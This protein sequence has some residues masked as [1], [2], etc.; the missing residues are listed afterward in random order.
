MSDTSKRKNLKLGGVEFKFAE[1]QPELPGNL[2]L[3]PHQKEFF[4]SLNR[5]L[6]QGNSR[7]FFLKSMT[8]SGKTIANIMPAINN[9]QNILITYPTNQLIRDQ[10]RSIEKDAD[11]FNFQED[12]E[13]KYLN[14]RELQREK[15]REGKNISNLIEEKLNNANQDDSKA[16]IFLTSPD[17]LYNILSAKYWRAGDFSNP[18]D[19]AHEAVVGSLDYFVFDEFHMYDISGETSILNMCLLLH[20]NKALSKPIVFSSATSD[21]DF[22]DNLAKVSKNDIKEIDDNQ[23]RAEDGDIQI[24][25]KVDL[26][27][28]LG[29]KWKGPQK[30]IEEREKKI[31]EL[32]KEETEMTA[33]FESVKNTT[34]VIDELEEEFELSEKNDEISYKTGFDSSN[35]DISDGR[36]KLGTQTISVGIDFSTSDLFFESYRARDFLQ[37]LGRVGREGNQ[38]KAVCYTSEY[39]IPGLDK[40]KEEYSDRYRFQN[41][42]IGSEEEEGA[43]ESRNK[44]WRYP[45]KY[46]YIELGNFKEEFA[47]NLETDVWELSNK[48][49]RRSPKS[50]DRYREFI[51]NFRDPGTPQIAVATQDDIKFRDLVRFFEKRSFDREQHVRTL[52]ADEKDFLEK[53][54]D[55]NPVN[56]YYMERGTIKPVL[57][58]D[59]SKGGLEREMHS[60]PKFRVSSEVENGLAKYP[61]ELDVE[62][63]LCS[64]DYE[65][66]KLPRKL[67]HAI[68]DQLKQ[69]SFLLFIMTEERYEEKRGL[70][71]H[72]FRTYE[73]EG[74][75]DKNYRIAFG[76][77]ALKLEATLDE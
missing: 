29:K 17:T 63:T 68:R 33:I 74:A 45:Q 41:D 18:M 59:L 69:G 66:D 1:E 32:K 21:E 56:A 39:S 73:L 36:L 50:Q 38:S 48:L 7:F 57:I 47:L 26:E 9:K 76:Q 27:I 52:V 14:A 19:R 2:K 16:Y 23:S 58:Y 30:F 61:E 40:L 46:G 34:R 65:D 10:K 4:N 11:E 55:K 25:G 13:V 53:H 62:L 20:D 8:G 24:A 43:M 35:N 28:V 77:N 31:L 22:K 42:L 64:A 15:Q 54:R 51:Q 67:K 71:P 3:F 6:E 70:V 5:D 12:V 60:S 72:L 49:Y 44:M 75:G 37:K